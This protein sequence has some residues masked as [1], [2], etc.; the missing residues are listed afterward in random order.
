[1]SESLAEVGGDHIQLDGNSEHVAYVWRRKV[2]LDKKYPI[3][4]CSQSN[5]IP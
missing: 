5:Q 3:C 2:F 1:M 4:D